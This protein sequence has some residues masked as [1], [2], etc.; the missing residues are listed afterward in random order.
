[1]TGGKSKGKDVP[2][3]IAITKGC[4]EELEDVLKSLDIERDN[5]SIISE[6]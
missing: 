4:E 6:A 2:F 3:Y 1:M 5:Y